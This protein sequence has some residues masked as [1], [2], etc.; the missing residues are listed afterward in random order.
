MEHR[1]RRH[2]GLAIGIETRAERRILRE[3]HRLE[4]ALFGAAEQAEGAID[5]AAARR[6][7]A[8]GDAGKGAH[9]GQRILLSH[10]DHV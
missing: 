1:A 3:R 8:P 6:H 5:V 7:D 4:R 9:D 2:V 10:R